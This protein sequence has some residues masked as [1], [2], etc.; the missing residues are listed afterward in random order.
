MISP[1]PPAENRRSILHP[2]YVYPRSLNPYWTSLKGIDR[3]VYMDNATESHPGEW[4]R[5]LQDMTGRAPEALHVEVGCNGGHVVLEWA[6]RR[7]EDGYIGLDWKFKQIYRGYE[8][9]EKRGIKNL[10]FLRAHAVRIE[11]MFAPGEIDHLYLFFPDPWPKKSQWKNR[12]FTTA[13][14]KRAASLIRTGGTFE[15]RTDHSGYFQWMQEELGLAPGL[16]EVT[17]STI[18]H[19]ET[20]PNPG[21]LQIPE[22]TLF[23]K[24][25]IQDG[26]KI[27]RMLLRRI[28]VVQA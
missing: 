28:D 22:V 18:D 14:L 9:A 24:L 20:H 16:F 15:I 6:D 25:F 21:A 7:K 4:K 3:H 19:Y 2:E 12:L 23:E 10:I 1:T 17:E 8:K 26:I 27:K 13:W 11:R 5:L